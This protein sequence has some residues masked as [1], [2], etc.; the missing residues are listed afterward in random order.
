[1]NTGTIAIAMAG[2]IV[3]A[4]CG[5]PQP[6]VMVETTLGNIVIEIYQDRAPITANNFLRLVDD[7][8]YTGA[9]FYRSVTETNQPGDSVKI[10]VIQGGLEDRDSGLVPIVHETTS[11]TGV[12]HADGV[13]SMARLEPGTASSEFFI[14]IG[15]Q[16]ELDAGGKRNPDRQGFAA[17]GRVLEGMDVVR[18]IHRQP[19]EGQKLAPPIPIKRIF[20]IR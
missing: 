13:I 8:R 9:A 15:N 20:R 6:R 12:R 10:E 5:R 1:M 3:F 19:V 18:T 16:P 2:V 7:G 17:F 4:G 14:C 11:G